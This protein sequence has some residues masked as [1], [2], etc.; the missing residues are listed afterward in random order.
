[1]SLQWGHD[2]IVMEVISL[3]S[4]ILYG[5]ALQWGHDKIVM[6]V[7]INHINAMTNHYMLQWGH[8]K[9]VMEVLTSCVLFLL[10]LC[11]SMGP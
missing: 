2:K 4:D 1:M 9:I 3:M 10:L 11:A 5:N 7:Y 6:E 8:D